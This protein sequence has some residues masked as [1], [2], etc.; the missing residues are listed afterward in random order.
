ML[1]ILENKVLICF[2]T[3][4]RQT[5]VLLCVRFI[6]VTLFGNK[7]WS[8]FTASQLTVKNSAQKTI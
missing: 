2:I 3:S 7:N 8:F 6:S 4:D 1:A 5:F